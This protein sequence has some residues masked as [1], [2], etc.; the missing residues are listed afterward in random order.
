MTLTIAW[1]AL[2][3]AGA[4]GALMAVSLKH[5]A[6]FTDPLWT[7]VSL[8]T[9]AA[10]ILL[11]GLSLQVLPAGTVFSAWSGVAAV[12]AVA[13]GALVMGERLDSERAFWIGLIV[14]GV[15]GLR[16]DRLL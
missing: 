1:S 12:L 8:G 11:L 13:T 10:L 15:L 5:A 3:A 6:G 16:Y 2:L 9:A 4:L 14:L 7:T